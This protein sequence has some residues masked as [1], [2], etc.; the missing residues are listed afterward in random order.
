MR[1]RLVVIN[2]SISML[3][4]VCDILLGFVSRKLFIRYIGIAMLGVNGTFASILNTL[5]LAELGFESAV[6]YSLYKPLQSGDREMVEDIMAVLRAIYIAV[7]CFVFLAGGLLSFFLPG[8]L[9]GIEVSREI[10]AVYFLQLAGTT[11]TYFM[12]YKRTFLLALQKDYIRNLFITFYKMGATVLQIFLIFRFRSFV[13]YS[14]VSIL[15]NILTNVSVSVYVDRTETFRFRKRKINRNIFRGLLA[16][17]RDIFFGKIAG[18]VY[19]STDN[20]VISSCVSTIAVG[21]LGNYTQIL[22]QMKAVVT[23][24]LAST[25]PVIGHFLTAETDREHSFQIL[26]NYSFIRFVIAVCTL[27][28]GFTL[29]DVFI[30]AWIGSEYVLPKTI[31]LLL[32]SDIYIH[33]VHGALVDF[34]AGLGFFHQ[35]RNVSIVGALINIS[36]SLALVRVIGIGG[37]LVG[38]VVSQIYFWYSRSRIIFRDYYHRSR[39]KF[40][41]YW[42]R[43]VEYTLIFYGLCALLAVVVDRMG[44]RAGFMK[45]LVGGIVNYVIIIPVLFAIFYKSEEFRYVKTLLSEAVRKKG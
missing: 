14:A 40:L 1:K 12:A 36:V 26:M 32:V 10:F 25:K 27:V 20:L 15:Q 33:F 13:I 5:S 11:V 22:Y 38:T 39:G 35:D 43:C 45:F 30:T 2:G 31:S 41:S 28:P 3:C 23:N 37:V 29:C 17:V 18:Y 9:K 42:A 44:M 8:L 7:G 4:Q 16:N 21:L 24:V 6:I 19:S 34:I